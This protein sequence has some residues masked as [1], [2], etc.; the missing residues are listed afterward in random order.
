MF[1]TGQHDLYEQSLSLDGYDRGLA[2]LPGRSPRSGA[3]LMISA[4]SAV[5]V[6]T[7]KRRR[8]LRLSHHEGTQGVLH[9]A[10]SHGTLFPESVWRDRE[11]PPTTSATPRLM[12]THVLD[13]FSVPLGPPR[14]THHQGPHQTRGQKPVRPRVEDPACTVGFRWGRRAIPR[15][16]P[17]CQPLV[18]ALPRWFRLCGRANIRECALPH[19]LP[20]N[21]TPGWTVY[22]FGSV[23][24]EAHTGI[25]TRE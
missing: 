24:S 12:C 18:R 14:R 7:A 6:R 25:A 17:A 20:S 23:G 10:E 15:G 22:L 3:T 13:S 16:Q 9:T 2:R 21:S 5:S 11:Q 8:R 19:S 4:L 1:A